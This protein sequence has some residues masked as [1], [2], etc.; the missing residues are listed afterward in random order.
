MERVR[1]PPPGL[2]SPNA[3]A[4]RSFTAPPL[5]FPMHLGDDQALAADTGSL[6]QIFGSTEHDQAQLHEVLLRLKQQATRQLQ[7]QDQQQKQEQ[8]VFS[9]SIPSQIAASLFSSPPERGASPL[10]KKMASLSQSGVRADTP[11]GS[12]CP[13]SVSITGVRCG[14]WHRRQS[15][16]TIHAYNILSAIN[17]LLT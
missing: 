8:D 14:N 13:I 3:R 15:R 9:S 16:A 11:E 6:K 1:R 5:Q 4:V 17:S 10:R 2:A 12:S 7:E